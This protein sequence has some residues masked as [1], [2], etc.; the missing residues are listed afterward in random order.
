MVLRSREAF[1]NMTNVLD[2]RVTCG[3]E[4]SRQHE[5]HALILFFGK[6][7]YRRSHRRSLKCVDLEYETDIVGLLS[8]FIVQGD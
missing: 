3:F 1:C 6:T 5:H 2:C 8:I 7:T 4:H